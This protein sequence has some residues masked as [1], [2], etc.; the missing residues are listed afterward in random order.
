[1]LNNTTYPSSDNLSI[2]WR[3]T[4]TDGEK[5]YNFSFYVNYSSHIILVILSPVTVV[6]NAFILAAI[7]SRAFQ[8]TPF[9]V[10]LSG[11][12]F[13]DLCT[14]LISQP[15]FGAYGLLC[16]VNPRIVVRQPVLVMIIFIIGMVSAVY[17]VVLSFII[18]AVMSV[19]R[20]LYMVR[21]SL[22][23]SRHGRIIFAVLLLIP[24]APAV[25]KTWNNMDSTSKDKVNVSIGSV[26]LFCYFTTSV[27]YVNVFRIIRQHQQQVQG[28]Q[29][30]QNFG[31][32]AINLAKY[33]KSVVSI[34][35]ILALFSFCFLPMI[36]SLV[37]S[38]HVGD[39]Q[40]M[41]AAFS[42]SFVLLILSSLLNPILYLWRMNDIRNRVK[43]LLCSSV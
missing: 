3:C 24:I 4:S 34:L 30:S 38:A 31:Q 43:Q 6:G 10:L 26:M 37:I 1:M 8:R 41:K 14:G 18:M 5:D 13:T 39:I 16:L 42:V 33:K 19:E 36:V 27:A 23:T 25:L 17:F 29:S 9:H 28:N 40:E 21:R 15:I 20:W 12:A 32:P 35:Y 22:V 7:W 2:P 11:L